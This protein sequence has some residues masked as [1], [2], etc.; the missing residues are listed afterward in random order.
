MGKKTTRINPNPRKAN[1]SSLSNLRRAVLRD[2]GFTRDR[3]RKI[4]SNLLMGLWLFVSLACVTL[5]FAR[6]AGA[7]DV[8]GATSSIAGTVRVNT[9]QGQVNNIAGVA[10]KLSGSSAGSTPQS[11]LTD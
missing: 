6:K 10:V 11:A 5:G 7:S 1:K 9:G 2:A 4:G 3:R 8:P